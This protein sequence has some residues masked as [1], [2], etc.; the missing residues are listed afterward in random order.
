[1]T[2]YSEYAVYTV[3]YL[4]VIFLLA[5]NTQSVAYNI[6]A[7]NKNILEYDHASAH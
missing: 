2:N 4:R 1:M 5:G 3:T 7:C 6:K